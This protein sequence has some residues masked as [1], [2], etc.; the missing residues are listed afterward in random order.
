MTGSSRSPRRSN[1]NSN[2]RDAPVPR[3]PLAEPRAPLAEPLAPLAEPLAGYAHDPDQG[4][5]L[6]M[7]RWNLW[8]GRE[9]AHVFTRN[10][11]EHGGYQYQENNGTWAPFDDRTQHTLLGRMLLASPQVFDIV[12]EGWTYMIIL[13]P[14][15]TLSCTRR[16]ATGQAHGVQIATHPGSNNKPRFLRYIAGEP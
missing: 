10:L 11:N 1:R 3:A 4:P 15:R 7:S 6:G 14:D 5:R 2:P 8:R 9:M 12:V 13:D 16:D